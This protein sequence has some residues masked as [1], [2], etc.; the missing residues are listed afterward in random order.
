MLCFLLENRCTAG[1]VP[2]WCTTNAKFGALYMQENQYKCHRIWKSCTVVSWWIRQIDCT[3][4]TQLFGWNT[5]HEQAIFGIND[6]L[7]VSYIIIK[8]CTY[9]DFQH[10]HQMK[11]M[12]EWS[13]TFQKFQ[14]TQC[15]SSITWNHDAVH[16]MFTYLYVVRNNTMTLLMR[17]D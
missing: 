6:T 2:P 17:I 15:G 3:T 11:R 16:Y 10:S 12:G 7:I 4:C 8:V 13:R 9:N 14:R 1:G 5:C